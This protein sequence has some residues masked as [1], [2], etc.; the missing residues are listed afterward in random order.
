MRGFRFHLCQ[1]KR[2][3]ARINFKL[4]YLLQIHLL[5]IHVLQVH[6][7]Q[8]HLFKST[9]YKSTP[10]FTNPVHSTP[11][12]STPCFTICL[13]FLLL[14]PFSLIRDFGKQNTRGNVSEISVSLACYRQIE[15]KS[16]NHSHQYD[17]LTFFTS[18]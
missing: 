5:Q 15:S 1:K 7:L 17:L 2:T 18:C 10:C 4:F 11:I 16:T 14:P 3:V 8:I 9:F 13:Y 12:Q 6:V